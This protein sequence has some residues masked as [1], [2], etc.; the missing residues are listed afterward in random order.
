M[1][2]RLLPLSDRVLIRKAK[3][4][5]KI[6]GIILPESAQKKLNQGTVLAVGPGARS[7]DGS[8]IPPSV[9][10]G[11]TVCLSEYG[12]TEVQ[13]ADGEEL[14]LYREDDILAEATQGALYGPE[15]RAADSNVRSA[16]QRAR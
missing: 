9:K 6:G 14:Y 4:V 5:E 8:L 7:K 3:P 10:E 11:D 12:G 13:L 15:S 2:K 16:E 1:F